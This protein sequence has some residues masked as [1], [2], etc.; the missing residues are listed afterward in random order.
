MFTGIIEEIGTVKQ[1]KKGVKSAELLIEA[2]KI[3][4]DLKL[5]DSVATNGVCLTVTKINGNLFS[6]DVMNE[7][8]KRSRLGDLRQGSSVNLE[9]AMPSN[10][11]FGGH[12]VSGHIDGVGKIIS[13][14]KD[15]IAFWYKISAS[16][17]IMRYIIEKGSITI[18]GISLT[19]AKTERD[20]FSVSIIPHTLSQTILKDKK[21][22]SIVNL[23][24]DIVG[25]YIEKFMTV[26]KGITK[27]FLT[28]NGF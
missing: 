25:K 1:I 2:K 8:I 13:I 7:T 28:Q 3:F 17:E 4:S 16:S 22:G 24:N 6:A 14:S 20:N 26:Q 12:I 18:D 21:I 19:V 5:G 10:G 15:D 11:R 27:D 9:R 23:E